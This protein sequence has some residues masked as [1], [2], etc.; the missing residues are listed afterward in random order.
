MSMSSTRGPLAR[1]CMST[2]PT[3]SYCSS[4]L[5]RSHCAVRTRRRSYRPAR[6]SRFLGARQVPIVWSTVPTRR[7]VTWWCPRPTAPTSSNT[8]TQPRRWWSLPSS[9][10][11]IRTAPTQT[12]RPSSPKQCG[13]RQT[14][15]PDLGQDRSGGAD[16]QSTKAAEPGSAAA[17]SPLPNSGEHAAGDVVVAVQ[18]EA[19]SSPLCVLSQSTILLRRRLGRGCFRLPEALRFRLPNGDDAAGS[20]KG[21]LLASQASVA[22]SIPCTSASI[23]GSCLRPAHCGRTVPQLDGVTEQV[24]LQGAAPGDR[25]R[26]VAL[27]SAA[28]LAVLSPAAQYNVL[29]R[30]KGE[31]VASEFHAQSR[32]RSSHFA[33]YGSPRSTPVVPRR[34]FKTVRLLVST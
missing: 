30:S 21:P 26:A 22:P 15:M 12:K 23:L 29:A 27:S 3:R 5:A 25:G 33:D 16:G 9:A 10:S 28:C 13:R 34:P 6:W 7:F 2:T 11:P 17:W 19:F 4:S 20:V 8:P 24:D 14:E 1:R 32:Q 31:K 18:R